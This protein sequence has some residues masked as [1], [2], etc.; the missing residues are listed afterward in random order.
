MKRN[1]DLIRDILFAV[2]QQ[3][4]G[5]NAITLKARHFGD[6]FPDL[7]NEI[8]DEHIHLLVDA[9]FLEAEPHQLGWFIMRLTWDGHCFIDNSKEEFVWKKTKRIAGDFSLDLFASTLKTCAAAYLQ[10]FL[11][12]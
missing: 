10:S 3:A 11:P 8:V 9:G 1:N 4:T 5:N 7:T 2:E 12:G 6:K